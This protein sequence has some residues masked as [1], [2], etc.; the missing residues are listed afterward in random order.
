M[1]KSKWP[2]KGHINA[3]LVFTGHLRILQ[4]LA[5]QTGNKDKHISEKPD[6]TEHASYGGV[7]EA[8]I[9]DPNLM[10]DNISGGK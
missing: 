2:E 4:C 8:I 9:A 7:D 3:L 1:L 6:N 5:A 10:E